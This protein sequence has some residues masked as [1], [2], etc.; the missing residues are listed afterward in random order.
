MYIHITLYI[1]YT[2]IVKA[3][4]IEF[5]LGVPSMQFCIFIGSNNHRA[6]DHD[7]SITINRTS[8]KIQSELPQFISQLAWFQLQ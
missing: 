5:Q 2:H 4:S 6:P 1:L 7:L 3:S 8:V